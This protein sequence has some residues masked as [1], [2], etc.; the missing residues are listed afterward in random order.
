MKFLVLAL[1]PLASAFAPAQFGVQSNSALMAEPRPDTSELIQTALEASK[2]FGASSAEARLAW[3]TVEEMDA[4]SR[5]NSAMSMGTN[6]EECEVEDEPS[7]ACVDYGEKMEELSKLI[8]Q[9]GPVVSSLKDIALEMKAIK[10]TAVDIPT[11]EAN[12]AIT[13]AL[14]DAKAATEE[15][16]ADS[17]EAM[18][19]W[20]TLEE[21]SSSSEASGALGGR[22]DEECLTD[23]IEACQGL[24][25]VQRVLKL[26]SN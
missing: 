25:E 1:L 24:E 9:S 2:K 8:A 16:G 23:M 22:L 4:S 6:L 14:K 15:F 18:L 26:K 11:G 17:T 21:I 3:E 7:K 12:P 19:A 13:E 20:E 5:T 10:L